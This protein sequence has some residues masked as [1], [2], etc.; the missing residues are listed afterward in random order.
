MWALIVKNFTIFF[1]GCGRRLWNFG[2]EK[3]VLQMIKLT[4]K[5]HPSRNLKDSSAESNTD[6]GGS[7]SRDF[8]K[9][10]SLELG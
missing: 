9:E 2:L 8:R 4:L 6:Y 10:P 5:D 7:R 3:A 1:K